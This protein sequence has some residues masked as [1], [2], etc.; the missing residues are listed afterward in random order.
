VSQTPRPTRYLHPVA[1]WLWALALA[2]AA[3]RT[4]NPLLLAAIIA[5]TALVVAARRA[6]T[7]WA[8]SFKAFLLLGAF[9]LG[10]RVLFEVLFGAPIP[11][12]TVF[13]LPEVSLPEWMAGVR[14]GGEVTLEAIVAALY[15]GLQLVAILACVGAANCLAN[16]TRLLKSVPGALYE[17]GVAIVVALTLVPSAVEHMHQVRDARRLRGRSTKGARAN[18]RMAAAVLT[19]ARERSLAIA[20]ATDSRGFGRLRPLSRFERRVTAAVVLTGLLTAS[21]GGYA[22]LD[23]STPP[24]AAAALLVSGLVLLLVGLV[25]SNR[26]ATRTVYRPDPWRWP[27][28]VTVAS[29]VVAL[30]TSTVTVWSAPEVML[31]S[32]S[33]LVWPSLPLLPLVGIIVAAAPAWITP[34]VPQPTARDVASDPE[35]DSALV[36]VAA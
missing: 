28:S 36:G 14:L 8:R 35:F 2:A 6:D 26:R 4:L 27:E 25:R 22:L 18:A 24:R 19:G 21:I 29:A 17:V 7:P 33:P 10:I 16:P 32:T 11:G 23:A 20:A 15:S 31:P 5:V 34:P 13:T 30:V 3:S 1:W 12:T 9:V